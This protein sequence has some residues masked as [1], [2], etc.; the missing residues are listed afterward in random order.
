MN[1]VITILLCAAAIGLCGG[2]AHANPEAK[3]AYKRGRDH[4][5]AGEYQ[6]AIVEL[7]RAYELKPHPRLLRYMGDAYFK[8][9]KAREAIDHYKRYL[10]Q[11]PQAADRAKVEAKV[12]KLELVVGTGD[13]ED[14]PAPPPPPPPD[15]DPAPPPPSA[16]TGGGGTDV[17]LAPTGEDKENPLAAPTRRETPRSTQKDTSSGGSAL[18]WLKWVAA[19]VA[20]AGLAMGITFNRLA[21]ADASDLEEAVKT[22]CL[23]D[24]SGCTPRPNPQMNNPQVPFRREHFDLEQSHSQNQ[25]ISI[26]TFVTG[27]VA[28]GAAVLLFVLDKPKRG[29]RASVPAGSRVG[30][31]P[32]VGPGYYGVGGEVTF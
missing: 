18:S 27:G 15:P 21:A 6:Q 24:E 9:N 2:V 16:G 12:R 25:A 17:N 8:L 11:A 28:A 13:E 20:V 1:R 23:P 22:G 31:A 32:V 4:Y 14:E 19:G 10:E 5:K 3:E 7:K 29:K 30:V 26:A